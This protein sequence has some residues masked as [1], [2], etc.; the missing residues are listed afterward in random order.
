[1]IPLRCSL[2]GGYHVNVTSSNV[3]S[4]TV[5]LR[6]GV[7]GTANKYI[8]RPLFNADYYDLRSTK[9]TQ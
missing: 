3:V 2:K 5:T 9:G 7:L 4:T 6:G 8:Y 1:M